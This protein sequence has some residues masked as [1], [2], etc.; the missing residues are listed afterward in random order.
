MAC[1]WRGVLDATL[2]DKVCQ[3]PTVGRWFSLGHPVYSTNKT[4]RHD[5]TKILLKLALNTISLAALCKWHSQEWQ[6]VSVC[7]LSISTSATKHI[8]RLWLNMEDYCN[9]ADHCLSFCV[10]CNGLCIVC[11]SIV[12]FWLHL[13]MF[14]LFL[15]LYM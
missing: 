1:L 4:D 7:S 2:C 9:F 3:W 15:W 11:P 10:C 12:G 5:S 13:G 14:K 6:P 8:T